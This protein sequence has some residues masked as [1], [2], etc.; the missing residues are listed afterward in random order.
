MP[1]PASNPAAC[2]IVSDLGRFLAQIQK[3]RPPI[4]PSAG[5]FQFVGKWTRLDANS[6][7]PED[8][9]RAKHVK[10]TG[11]QDSA[12]GSVFNETLYV[13]GIFARAVGLGLHANGR[14]WNSR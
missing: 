11:Q 3:H 6:H 2:E 13:Q 9:I 12:A 4:E 14:R 10:I 5:A 1:E 8:S 7:F